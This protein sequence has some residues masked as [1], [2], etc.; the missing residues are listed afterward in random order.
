MSISI[1]PQVASITD[2][3]ASL[4][5]TMN[6][7][8]KAY[9]ELYDDPERHHLNTK[10]RKMRSELGAIRAH[11]D[12][13]DEL[14]E[15]YK[16][17]RR[18]EFEEEQENLAGPPRKKAKKG[19]KNARKSRPSV[20]TAVQNDFGFSTIS[21]APMPPFRSAYVHD[22]PLP[23][24]SASCHPGGDLGPNGAPQPAVYSRARLP[25]APF[26][27][28]GASTT[29]SHRPPPFEH[30]HPYAYSSYDRAATPSFSISNAVGP[31]PTPYAHGDSHPSTGRPYPR[32]PFEHGPEN[33]HAHT[34]QHG[35]GNVPPL[36]QLHQRVAS[37]SV[38]YPPTAPPPSHL[39]MH[40][41]TPHHSMSSYNA[42]PM[43]S[44]PQPLVSVSAAS[45]AQ[46]TYHE[47][48]TSPTKPTA[49]ARNMRAKLEKE[50][51]QLSALFKETGE[52]LESRCADL[53]AE[54]RRIE[55]DT[56]H[57][58]AHKARN[59]RFE[60]DYDVIRREYEDAQ[61]RADDK[62]AYYTT[63]GEYVVETGRQ[64]RSQRT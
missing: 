48:L 29:Y 17:K 45:A 30:H 53:T 55:E 34:A 21:I 33:P 15:K 44:I 36:P 61:L 26:H 40:G 63:F 41:N 20:V 38:S 49:K 4:V 64:P 25:L 54:I 46:P 24:M 51:M 2:N 14:A 43:Q 52:K 50:V 59:A 22:H 13:L 10:T 5:A 19:K 9:G 28:P 12:H 27:Q 42:P 6:Q 35:F 56:A 18:Q 8:A 57:L 1:V 31:R 62:L 7:L 47:K 11:T 37:A 58:K 32:R 3:A 60:H 39:E 16:A 23:P